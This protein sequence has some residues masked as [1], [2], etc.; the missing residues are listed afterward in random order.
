VTEGGA[1][2]RIRLGNE[3]VRVAGK[4]SEIKIENR[5]DRR[6]EK[7]GDLAPPEYRDPVIEAYKRDVDRTLLRENLKLT[8]DERFRKFASFARFVEEL[9]IAGSKARSTS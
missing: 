2:I 7:L 6:L 3:L 4:M 1:G 8:P 9:Q 5:T